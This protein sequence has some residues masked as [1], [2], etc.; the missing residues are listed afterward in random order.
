MYTFGVLGLSCEAGPAEGVRR[1]R[2]RR[3]G[4][5]G[6]RSWE[7]G[8]GGG[9][10]RGQRPNL[11]R[12]HENLEHTPHRHTHHNTTG[13]PAQ[14]GLGPEKTRHEQQ[15]VPKSSHWPRFFGSTMVAKV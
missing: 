13:D 8:S 10:S 4:S 3:R 6:R 7:R 2:S 12:A 15:I 5:R 14:G 9:G 11:G 1:R